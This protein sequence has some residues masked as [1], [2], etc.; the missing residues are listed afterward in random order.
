MKGLLPLR[1]LNSLRNQSDNETEDVDGYF[2]S[3]LHIIKISNSS[4]ATF[5]KEDTEE[6]INIRRRN[7]YSL[8]DYCNQNKIE[9]LYQYLDDSDIPYCFPII[10]EN[11]RLIK[12]ALAEEGIESEISINEPPSREL[13]NHNNQ[14]FDNLK[15]LSLHCLSIP[16]HQ[17]IDKDMMDYIKDNLV[18]ILKK[19]NGVKGGN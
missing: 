14:T 8:L 17:N 10:V 19:N 1:V 18:A 13:V 6:I 3:P 4:L 2:N 7:F 15:K 12:K 9:S 16:I 5:I 11:P